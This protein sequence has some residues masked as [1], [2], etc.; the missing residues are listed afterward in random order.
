M[1]FTVCWSF[2]SEMENNLLYRVWEDT[3]QWLSNDV[4]LCAAVLPC[5]VLMQSRRT[6]EILQWADGLSTRWSHMASAALEAH[7][8]KL[9]TYAEAEW[10]LH[11]TAWEKRQGP[12]YPL[13]SVSSLSRHCENK[14]PCC[15]E[16]S[17]S[18]TN[19]TTEIWENDERQSHI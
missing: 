19:I 13:M 8:R 18:H 2:T 11:S 14:G 1:P 17:S 16:G 10:V 12:N 15:S 7:L 9:C 6:Q 3:V 4:L 5:S